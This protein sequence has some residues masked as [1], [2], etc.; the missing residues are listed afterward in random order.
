MDDERS[1]SRCTE[2]TRRGR[3]IGDEFP[4]PPPQRGSACPISSWRTIHTRVRLPGSAPWAPNGGRRWLT[5]TA[6]SGGVLW[7]RYWAIKVGE[8]VQ[9]CAG[10][11][12]VE[13]RSGIRS[14]VNHTGHARSP[15]A[16]PADPAWWFE[17]GVS[18]R[19][20]P[21]AGLRTT[22][23]QHGPT[24]SEGPPVGTTCQVGLAR[25]R[26]ENGPKWRSRPS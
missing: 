21:R 9:R 17:G 14:R 8:T 22:Q 25:W 16:Q 15:R 3:Y 18:N 19:R 5:T 11:I 13:L 1:Q 20:A 6:A 10:E 7:S 4:P 26:G 24:N 2:E 12:F 23:A